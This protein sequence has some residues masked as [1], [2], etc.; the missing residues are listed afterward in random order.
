LPLTNDLSYPGAVVKRTSSA[1]QATARE[2]WGY[3]ADLMFTGESQDRFLAAC[4]AADLSP[5]QLK[6]LLS[7]EPGQPQ[8]MRALAATW[9]CDASW[10]TGLVDGLEERGYARRSPH[11][12]DRRV[13]VVKI[14]DLGR[15][16]KA[17]AL[18]RLHEPPAALAELSTTDLRTLRDILRKLPAS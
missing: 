9:N 12:T 7:M 13:K 2:A 1:A 15:K 8:S 14:T 17:Q 3:I 6:A 16:A 11:P 18:E 5:P 4:R 10:V